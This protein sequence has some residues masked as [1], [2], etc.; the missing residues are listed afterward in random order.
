MCKKCCKCKTSSI[1][2]E[3]SRGMNDGDE[4]ICTACDDEDLELLCCECKTSIRIGHPRGLN[5]YHGYKVICDECGL[6]HEK[7]VYQRVVE[8]YKK[9]EKE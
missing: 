4:F 5:A 7:E 9:K 8:K 2:L 1:R 3:D 6:R